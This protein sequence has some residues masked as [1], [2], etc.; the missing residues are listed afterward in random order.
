MD[1]WEASSVLYGRCL[2]LYRATTNFSAV[3]PNESL[4]LPCLAA[5]RPALPFPALPDRAMPSLFIHSFP[6]LPQTYQSVGANPSAP[7]APQRLVP[8]VGYRPR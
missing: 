3:Y 2:Q 4:A 8:T 1:K 5:P 6:T 7:P